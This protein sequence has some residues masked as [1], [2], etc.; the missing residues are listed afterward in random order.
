MKLE[1]SKFAEA[2]CQIVQREKWGYQM[3]HHTHMHEQYSVGL[4][5]WFVITLKS[6]RHYARF[7]AE[8]RICF[9]KKETD[10][11]K[12]FSSGLEKFKVDVTKEN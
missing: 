2:T 6:C 4:I 3:S 1:K 9:E 11:D 7:D 5:N 8:S 10:V 12:N